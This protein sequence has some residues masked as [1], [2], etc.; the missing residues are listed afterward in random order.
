VATTPTRLMTV[1]EFDRIP[2]PPGGVYELYH[3]ELVKMAYPKI[4]HA[5]RQLHIRRLL[6]SA[7]ADAGVIKE[8]MAF[9]A[10]P[11]H[12]CW[13]ADVAFVSNER[14]NGIADWLI[15]AP[16]LVVEI[17]SPSNSLLRLRDKGHICLE[18]GC[19]EFW[20]VDLRRRTVTVLTPRGEATYGAGQRVPLFFDGE[21][22][23]DHIFE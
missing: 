13:A 23:V 18:N 12:E 7:A 4:P 8:E 5:K 15:G 17:I 22:A 14:W 1:E 19:R 21:I 6:E 16:E 9:R 3:G 10:L 20:I 11:E 2:N